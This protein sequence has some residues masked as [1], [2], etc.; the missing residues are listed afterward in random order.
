MLAQ[1]QDLLPTLTDLCGFPATEVPVDGISL[2]RFLRSESVASPDRTLI[3]QFSRVFVGRPQ[4]GDA[5]VLWRNWR[6]VS[7]EALYDISKDPAQQSNVIGSNRAVAA[8]MM[9][10]YDRWWSTVQRRFDSF[11]PT[12]IGGP[13]ERTILLSPADWADVLRSGKGSA[14]RGPA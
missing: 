9:A 4:W 11:L 2:A 8:Q 6:L 3:V 5:A 1:V 13:K 10:G 14:R 7:G 12:H